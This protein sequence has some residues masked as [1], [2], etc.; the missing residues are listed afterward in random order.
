MNYSWKGLVAG[1]LL[2]VTISVGAQEKVAVWD[3]KSCLSYARSQNIQ[4]RKS[5]VASEEGSENVLQAKAERLPSLSFSTSHDYTNHPRPEGGDRNSYSGSY[6]L[7]SSVSL[8]NSI[9]I[10]SKTSFIKVEKEHPADGI[11]FSGSGISCRRG[12]K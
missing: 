8:Y 7:R 1:L 12:G 3:F 6:A 5:R 9:D 2:S 10:K 11:A 4:I